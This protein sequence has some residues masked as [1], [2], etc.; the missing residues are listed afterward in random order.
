M[1]KRLIALLLV[2]V[3]MIP[4]GASLAATWYRVN[5]NSL[6]VRYLPADN[7]KVLAS[8]R[9]DYA[10]TI[11]SKSDGWAY[12]NFSNGFEG[13]VLLRYLAKGR[14]YSAWIY[15]D[16]T[17]LRKGPGGS[18]AAV[19]TL[20]RGRK[21]TVLTHGTNYD[22]VSAGSLGRGYVVN[23]L[24]SRKKVKA[25]GT[26][27]TAT[28]TGDV[29]YTAYVYSSNNGK[30]NLRKTPSK[31][32]PVITKYA[33]GT[34]VTVT[35]HGSEWDKIT[36]GSTTG[37]M[38]NKFLSKSEPAPTVTPKATSG[39]NTYT[40]YVVSGNKKSVNVRKGNSANYAV[41]FKINYG[42]PVTVLKRETK[43]SKISYAGKTGWISNSY[44][45]LKKPGD[46]P[47]MTEVPDPTE[48][49]K[50]KPYWATITSP[51]GKS[52]NFHRGKGEG[53]ANVFGV[54]RLAVGTSVYVLEL[55][56]KWAHIQYGNFKGWVYRKFTKRD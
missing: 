37:W 14:S 48:K 44:L 34:K 9:R 13:Y 15:R 17:A 42:T 50:F 38:M 6:N 21:V 40:A 8:Y 1:K 11:R 20:A 7:A 30:V 2:L 16:G 36:V 24:L 25:S 4:A 22:Y 56:G 27:S 53:Y 43:Y 32:S 47:T 18:Y 23:S 49:P 54:G 29:N 3:L 28:V 55:S 5:T 35:F 10:A 39:D 45:Q 31:N 51:D 41:K 12:V 33:T 46:A 26:K 19:A 52:V